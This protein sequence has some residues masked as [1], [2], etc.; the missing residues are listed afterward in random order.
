MVQIRKGIFRGIGYVVIAMF[1]VVVSATF[2]QVILRYVLETPVIWA[3]ELALTLMVWVTFLGAPL[4]L[5]GRQ[6]MGV[7]ALYQIV[8]GRAKPAV[9]I[10]ADALLLV[11]LVY[12]IRSGV[13]MVRLTSANVTPA[14]GISVSFMY[15]AIPAGGGLMV[16]Q[17][18][19]HLY[20]SISELLPG[21]NRTDDLP[22]GG[23]R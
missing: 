14:L 2:G 4:L 7:D 9:R 15:M 19:E 5:E 1:A 12:M 22:A 8:P 21:F 20:D 23:H 3:E 11:L 18:L 10:L 16:W 6:H 17:T 13:A